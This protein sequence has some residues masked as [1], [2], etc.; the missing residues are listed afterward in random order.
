M[1]FWHSSNPA[2]RAKRDSA[3]QAGGRALRIKPIEGVTLQTA[4]DIYRVLGVAAGDGL[5]LRPGALRARILG[6]LAAT[7]ARVLA[8]DPDLERRLA[9]LEA[10]FE[11]QEKRS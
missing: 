7:A 4:K 5:G 1:C 11:G 9:E 8:A 2:T 3:R 6:S 10:R